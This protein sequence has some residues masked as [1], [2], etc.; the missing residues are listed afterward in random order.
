[1]A[2]R[3]ARPRILCIGHERHHTDEASGCGSIILIV[4]VRAVA[5]PIASFKI[6]IE[7]GRLIWPLLSPAEIDAI[8]RGRVP[9][10]EPH[11]LNAIGRHC[12]I[13][14]IKPAADL[15][16]TVGAHQP[17]P[18]ALSLFL[19]ASNALSKAQANV[20]QVNKIG[21]HRRAVQGAPAAIAD[22]RQ[23]CALLDMRIAA[24]WASLHC[25][26][27]QVMRR[28]TRNPS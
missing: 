22:L 19:I 25:C 9:I 16:E 6:E 10:A 23:V 8:K 4:F 2:A 14:A 1:M 21:D 12:G 26:G 28:R 27:S 13:A 18:K 11:Y 24:F 7:P 17:I 20:L 5:R 3:T 15:R